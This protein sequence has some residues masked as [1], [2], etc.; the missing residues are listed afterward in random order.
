MHRTPQIQP[1]DQNFLRAVHY[2]PIRKQLAEGFSSYHARGYARCNLFQRIEWANTNFTY[3]YTVMQY[4]ELHK[5]NQ[6]TKTFFMPFI[7]D[8]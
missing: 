8:L 2:R 3:N 4:I 5:Y 6:E 1:G 7:I